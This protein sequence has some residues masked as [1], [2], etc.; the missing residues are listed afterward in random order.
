MR[1]SIAGEPSVTPT[2]SRRICRRTCKRARRDSG[3]GQRRRARTVSPALAIQPWSDVAAEPIRTPQ[4]GSPA[5][6]RCRHRLAAEACRRLGIARAAHGLTFSDSD[7]RLD[8][9]TATGRGVLCRALLCELLAAPARRST[10]L[11][12][13]FRWRSVR[14]LLT[15]LVLGFPLVPERQCGGLPQPFRDAVGAWLVVDPRRHRRCPRAQ[16]RATALK[17]FTE[18]LDTLTAASS[19]IGLAFLVASSVVLMPDQPRTSLAFPPV[20]PTPAHQWLAALSIPTTVDRR[21]GKGQN[22]AQG[23][24]AEPCD[25]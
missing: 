11:M 2:T 7:L 5:T 20:A 13:Y 3:A 23:E 25:S 21:S 18:N 17:P 12:I 19:L 15:G 9:R 8:W 4:I 16:A 6:H 24:G 22:Q 1:L 14:G 10:R